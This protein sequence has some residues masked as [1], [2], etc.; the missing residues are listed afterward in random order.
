MLA[1]AEEVV[2]FG[3]A[4]RFGT[5]GA[6]GLK[7]MSLSQATTISAAAQTR[8]SDARRAGP[9]KYVSRF[10]AVPPVL[11]AFADQKGAMPTFAWFASRPNDLRKKRL[12]SVSFFEFQHLTR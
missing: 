8:T 6:A 1:A 2:T 3:N 11:F 10:I 7:F 12:L 5:V 9:P 4:R